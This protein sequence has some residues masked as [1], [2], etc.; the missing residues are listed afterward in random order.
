MKKLI[1]IFLIVLTL[2]VLSIKK[3]NAQLNGTFVG[4]KVGFLLSQK[5]VFGL[6]GDFALTPNF[7]IEP[8]I[9]ATAYSDNKDRTIIRLSMEANGRY[10]FPF[11]GKTFEGF[12][13]A[14]PA[15]VIDRTTGETYGASSD[16]QFFR[17]NLGGGITFNNRSEGQ[18][19]TGV[20]VNF[21]IGQNGS[22]VQI[23][24][25]YRYFL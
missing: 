2:S 20:K 7:G 19:L 25:G 4:A 24:V 6:F 1:S 8:G 18:I 5:F 14:G 13:I 11:Q 21:D 10:S 23:F 12:A 22:D 15:Y 16:K 17:I 3:S 9:D